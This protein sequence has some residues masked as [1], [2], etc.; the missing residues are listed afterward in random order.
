MR[1]KS[2]MSR[3]KKQ[4]VL[5][6]DDT[7]TNIDILVDLLVD[8]DVLVALDGY[9]AIEI[10]NSENVDLVLL[11]IMMPDIDGYEVCKR[12]KA[13]T[14]TKDIPI[15]FI[16]AN[17]HEEFIEKA[18]DIGGIDYIT[19]PFKPKELLSRVATHLELSQKS[20]ALQEMY[21]QVNDSIKYA[22]NI[23][24]SILTDLCY[25]QNFFAKSFVLWQP[26]NKV[27]GDLYIFEECKDGIL[28]GVIDCTGHGVP[29]GFMTMLV[30]SII[31]GLKDDDISNDPAKIL[32]AIN[33]CVKTQLKQDNTINDKGLTIDNGLDAGICFI[34]YDKSVL[35]FAGAKIDLV[36]IR[37]DIL[38]NIKADKQ[39]L[40]YR[41]SKLDYL[42]NNHTI[43]LKSGDVFYI[44]SDGIKDQTGGNSGFSY[45]NKKL[46]ELLKNVHTK[47]FD[48][49]KNDI[50]ETITLYQGENIR[51]DDITML[52]FMI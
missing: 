28:C 39:S 45:G 24:Q 35:K 37:D 30:G 33:K 2:G 46:L 42:Y 16:T 31:K 40:G 36:H 51:K 38:T 15:I 3:Q 41:T 4:T 29:G 11:D 6:V 43:E 12:L 50:I 8:Y 26:K 9:S 18:Y 48:T 27:S 21:R 20:R 10:A 23:Q 17:T 7:E 19:K 22:R 49:Q 14:N 32:Q 1:G 25:I 52:G 5:I 44:Y 34:S 13:D 47:D